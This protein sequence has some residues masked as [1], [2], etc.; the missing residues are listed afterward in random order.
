MEKV[1]L[2]FIIHDVISE[3]VGVGFALGFGFGLGFGL[4]CKFGVSVGLVQNE[5]DEADDRERRPF[6]PALLRF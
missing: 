2:L 5:E 3:R 6:I 1:R 4:G